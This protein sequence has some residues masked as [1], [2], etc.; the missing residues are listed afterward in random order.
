MELQGKG[1]RLPAIVTRHPIGDMRE[2]YQRNIAAIL[3]RVDRSTFRCPRCKEWSTKYPCNDC[4]GTGRLSFAEL[5][6][7]FP[8][9][10]LRIQLNALADR[11]WSQWT[12]ENPLEPLYVA[13]QDELNQ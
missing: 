9:V 4:Y 8:R 7:K 11:P 6:D 5:A 3:E 1:Y 10:A 2:W 12:F 13:D